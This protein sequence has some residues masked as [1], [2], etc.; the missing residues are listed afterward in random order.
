MVA[1][2]QLSGVPIG[3]IYYHFDIA[4]HSQVVPQPSYVPQTL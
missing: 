1:L 2:P 4:E 3:N